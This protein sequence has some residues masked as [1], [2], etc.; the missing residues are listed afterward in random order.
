MTSH[1]KGAGKP[2]LID[3][4]IGVA[5]AL[6]AERWGDRDAL[7]SV[8]RATRYPAIRLLVGA[9]ALALG[10]VVGG[11]LVGDG[12]RS[13]ETYL[14]IA[15]AV[16]VLAGGLVDL[17]LAVLW[18]ASKG[19]AVLDLVIAPKTVLSLADVPEESALATIDWVRGAR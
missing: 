14:L 1:V 17:A 4:T 6:A 12:V 11:I 8:A 3:H 18:P 16:L 2:P 19:R 15:G 13:G 7:V 10:I 9:L 5:L